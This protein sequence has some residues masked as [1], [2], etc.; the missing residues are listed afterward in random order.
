MAEYTRGQEG[1]RKEHSGHNKVKL[2]QAHRR[3]PEVD[4]EAM[5]YEQ[6]RRPYGNN[7]DSSVNEE[8]GKDGDR[9]RNDL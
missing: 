7:P 3:L 1:G 9:R 4:F 5:N 2:E 8:R 6:R